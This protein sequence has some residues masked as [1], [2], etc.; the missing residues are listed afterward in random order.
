MLADYQER[1]RYILVDEY[2]DTN[3][4]QYLWLRLL[5]QAPRA[6]SAASATTTSRSM[7]GAARRST[8]SCA[9]STTSP[10]RTSIRLERNY[11]STGHILA[12][13]SDLI[14][15]NEGRLGKTL[16]TDDEPGEKVK[17]T[18]AWD[19]EEEA[20]LIGDEIEALQRR[21][22][23]STEMAILVRASVP[24]ARVRG[25]LHHARP[26][27]PVIGGPRF[28]ERLEI[29]DALAYLRCVAN[30]TDDLAFE[31]IVNT[32]KRGLGDATLELLHR[33]ARAQRA[34]R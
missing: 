30:P 31:R 20:R 19:C 29:R 4:A 13:A 26:A 17:V 16:C 3:V 24:D 25:A 1:F 28:Y 6:T 32:P 33:Y 10:A 21:A 23:R 9:S 34:C 12:A 8:T 15:H 5:A 27:L 11:R 14:A 7:A 22:I 2:Q 18:G